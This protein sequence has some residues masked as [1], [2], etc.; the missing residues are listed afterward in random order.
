MKKNGKYCNG[1]KSLNMK[2]LAL[3][4]ALTLLLGCA[5]GGTI[6]WLT[7]TTQEVENTFTVGN[8]DITLEETGATDNDTTDTDNTLKKSMKMVPGNKIEKDPKITVKAGSESCWVFVKVTESTSLNS[9]ITYVMDNAWTAL[10]NDYPG[11]YYIQQADL[12]SA[13]QNAVYNVIGNKGFDGNGKYEA[14]NVLVKTEV[15]KQMMDNLKV[16]GAVQP[17][18][19]FKAYAIQQASF[20]TPVAA[21]TEVSK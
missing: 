17:T 20:T 4:L 18:L 7:A 8:I 2:P 15:T 16:D 10:G 9:Y 6:A 11:V 12:S 21:W 1:K 5:I 14:N 3:L 13:T 19:T